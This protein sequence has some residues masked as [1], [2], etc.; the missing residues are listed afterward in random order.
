V[1]SLDF[2]PFDSSQGKLCGGVIL[3]GGASRH[4]TSILKKSEF[5]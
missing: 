3:I 1:N 2:R 5:F 4:P